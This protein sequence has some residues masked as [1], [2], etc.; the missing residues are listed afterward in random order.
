MTVK[1]KIVRI[2]EYR[3]RLAN[4]LRDQLDAFYASPRSDEEYKALA[5]KVEIINRRIRISTAEI[6]RLED[7]VELFADPDRALADAAAL[8]AEVAANSVQFY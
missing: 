6:A 4:D 3:G 8:T 1:Q 2:R 5:Q 7:A